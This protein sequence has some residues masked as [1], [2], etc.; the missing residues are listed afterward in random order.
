MHWHDHSSTWVTSLAKVF[1]R[2]GTIRA[3][4]HLYVND[5]WWLFRI[6]LSALFCSTHNGLIQ[7][8]R[9]SI[10]INDCNISTA[11]FVN[12]ESNGKSIQ[13]FILITQS[14]M[15]TLAVPY[16]MLSTILINGEPF[17]IICS[18]FIWNT[19]NTIGSGH[20][21]NIQYDAL[22]N[23]IGNPARGI[24]SFEEL[25]LRSEKFDVSRSQ[26]PNQHNNAQW[27][28]PNVVE[29]VH[30]GILRCLHCAHSLFFCLVS[31]LCLNEYTVSSLVGIWI[32]MLALYQHI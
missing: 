5:F 19:D 29:N 32:E 6:K 22:M 15:I 30:A 11:M 7:F 17:S 13:R 12:G 18:I 23:S 31:S 2:A 27:L 4:H 26:W 9:N 8:N 24:G 3:N 25:R 16:I 10:M 1:W 21:Y 14:H 20:C 28:W